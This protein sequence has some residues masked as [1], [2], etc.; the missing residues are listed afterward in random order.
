MPWK[1]SCRAVKASA[2]QPRAPA[3]WEA[4]RAKAVAWRAARREEHGRAATWHFAESLTLSTGWRSQGKI[5]AKIAELIHRCG[6]AYGRRPGVAEASEA[7]CDQLHSE[8]QLKESANPGRP[9]RVS[10]HFR[11]LRALESSPSVTRRLRAEGA[12]R[13]SPPVVLRELLLGDRG[14]AYVLRVATQ[15]PEVSLNETAYV[16]V[17]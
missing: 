15:A 16:A 11:K 12:R 9:P 5:E 3:L 1:D 7:L 10:L 6:W 17:L 2:E 8:F 4:P 14:A 13:T